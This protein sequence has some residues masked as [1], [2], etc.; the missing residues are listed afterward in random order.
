MSY[1][2]LTRYGGWMNDAVLPDST[3]PF[4]QRVRQRLRDEKVIWLT[5]VGA[6]GTPQ[7]NP[8][9]FLWDDSGLLVYNRPD[10]Y[11][12]RHIRHRNLVAAHFDGDG[13]GSDIVV[14][15]GEARLDDDAPAP[16]QHSSYLDKYAA[17]MRRVSDSPEAFSADYSV[18]VRIEITGVRGF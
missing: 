18:P 9:W 10:A 15:R 4:G 11:R 8:V 14:F 17:G 6:D 3:T 5:T 2:V 13:R 12:L 1:P 16:H 7:P